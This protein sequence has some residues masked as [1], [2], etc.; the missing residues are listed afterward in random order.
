[1]VFNEPHIIEANL[2]CQD[3]LFEGLLDESV[4]VDLKFVVGPLHLIE[5][6][7]IHRVVSWVLWLNLRELG[8]V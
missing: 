8:Q 2:V 5:K 4:V 7:K 6:S 1:M 3:Y